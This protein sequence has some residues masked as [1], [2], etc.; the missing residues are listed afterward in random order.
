MKL[1]KFEK[2]ENELD[3]LEY[4]KY[5][6]SGVK[7]V[8][9][10]FKTAFKNGSIEFRDN[11]IYLTYKG[12]EYK[13]YMYMNNYRVEKY[14]LPKFHLVQ[15]EVIQDFINSGLFKGKYSFANNRVNTVV[16]RDT[17]KE[18]K[19]QTLSC[20]K[21]CLQLINDSIE[22]TSDFYDLL[23]PEEQNKRDILVDID[24]YPLDWQKISKAYRA[25]MDYACENCGFQSTNNL[26]HLF[27]DVHHKDG[28]KLHNS[29]DNLQC[30]CKLCHAYVNTTHEKNFLG[31]QRMRIVLS[32]F[33]QNH[34]SN[35]KN[36]PYLAKVLNA[37][38]D[39]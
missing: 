26:D 25:K 21:Y 1:Y 11:G 27:L 5:D 12:V 28:D 3:R 18:H 6:S 38:K 32:K 39:A 15:C 29:E 36:N 2:L 24:G 33:I 34:K 30:L 8:R 17:R 31:N 37:L 9:T 20:C 13:G 16:D 7:I 14:G 35:L 22:T 23:T 19:D 10:D 4:L